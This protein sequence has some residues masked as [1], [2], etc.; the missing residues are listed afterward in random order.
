MSINES[1]HNFLSSMTKEKGISV[2]F[3]IPAGKIK[4]N[5]ESYD[6]SNNTVTIST[7]TFSDLVIGNNLTILT[8]AILAWGK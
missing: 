5:F 6:F 8:E 4:G 2:C 1:L 3:I 7:P